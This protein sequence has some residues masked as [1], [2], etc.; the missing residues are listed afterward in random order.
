VGCEKNHPEFPAL[1]T[2]PTPPAPLPF[3]DVASV[4]SVESF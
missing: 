4:G 2:V 1:L 3:W